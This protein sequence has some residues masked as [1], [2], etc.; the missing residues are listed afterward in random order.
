MAAH[1]GSFLRGGGWARAQLGGGTR[2]PLEQGQPAGWPAAAMAL[3][4]SPGSVRQLPAGVGPA[5]HGGVGGW[6]LG[7]AA[8]M[9]QADL[10]T[11]GQGAAGLA[12]LLSQQ[13]TAL[14]VIEQPLVDVV[15]VEGAAGD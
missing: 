3:T 5:R 7:G 6:W 2:P 10:A 14:G 4:S 9:S 11:R 1:T 15:L 12:R 8:G 13:P